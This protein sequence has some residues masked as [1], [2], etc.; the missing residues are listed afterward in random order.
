MGQ[1]NDCGW[2]VLGWDGNKL[3]KSKQTN[4]IDKGT[5]PCVE[6]RLQDDRT[7][8]YTKDHKILTSEGNW[9]KAKDLKIGK[10]RIIVGV[11]YPL[12]DLEKEIEECNEWSLTIED[13]KF[14]TNSKVQLLKTMAFARILGLLITDGHITKKDQ[15]M[16]VFLGHKLDVEQFLEDLNLFVKQTKYRKCKHCYVVRIPRVFSKYIAKLSGLVFGNKV[17]QESKIPDFI[18]DENCP[19]PIVREFLAGMFG[20]DGHTCFLGLHRGKRDLLTSIGFSRSKV[21][22]LLES[23]KKFMNDIKD[24]LARFDINEV[25]IQKPKMTSDSKNKENNIIDNEDVDDY[26]NKKKKAERTYEIVLHLSM[27]EL[28]PFHD[29]IG[30]RYCCHKNQRMEAGVSYKRLRNGVIRQHNWMTQRVDELTNFTQ[31]KSQDPN[32]KIRTKSAIAQATKEINEKEGLLHKYAIPTTHDI[33]DHLVKGTEFGKFTSTSFHNAD[34]YLKDVGAREW[35]EG[36]FGVDQEAEGLP[37][38]NLKVVSIRDV[39][40]KEVCDITVDET[41]SFLANGVVSHNC[42]IAHGMAQFL[43]ERLVNVSDLYHVHVCSRCGLFAR[44][45]P[46]KNIYQC[47]MCT[48]RGLSY[49]THKV[50][51]PY[52]FKL[53][54][55]E[56]MAINI[57]PRIKVN[58]SIYDDEMSLH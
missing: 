19:K 51:I 23:H 8:T 6:I 47:Q 36:E 15:E 28:I 53:L 12:V 56:L 21:K 41:E 46:D 50:E 54:V 33:T 7:V 38:M 55:Q 37:T 16:T 57:L 34:E 5:R 42:M 32:K 4:Y 20:G 43:K 58:A 45:K 14:K 13:F 30:F 25:T 1:M 3:I 22:S 31:I 27:N 39:G 24:L 2:D 11:D 9:V 40:D 26:S 10:D 18:L 49:T 29:K 52:A 17:N 44:K 48:S 35:F